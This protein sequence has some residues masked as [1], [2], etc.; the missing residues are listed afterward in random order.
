MSCEHTTEGRLVERTE[1]R[2]IP[3]FRGQRDE[4]DWQ[5][6]QKRSRQNSEENRVLPQKPREKRFMEERI[7]CDK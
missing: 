5:E 4:E 3:V 2:G 7:K 6:I 1:S